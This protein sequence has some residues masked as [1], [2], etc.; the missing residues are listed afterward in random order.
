MCVC[1]WRRDGKLIIDCGGDN[2]IE[3]VEVLRCPRPLLES[4]VMLL[5][6]IT[7]W[8]CCAV[9]RATF[10]KFYQLFLRE[11]AFAVKVCRRIDFYY[12]FIFYFISLFFGVADIRFPTTM[13]C[14]NVVGATH[15]LRGVLKFYVEAH[16]TQQ[17]MFFYPFF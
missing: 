15:L 3:S 6:L 13:A 14:H 12:L 2:N 17:E 5:C 4:Q 7:C 11:I 16:R 1:V 9:I 8:K 10:C